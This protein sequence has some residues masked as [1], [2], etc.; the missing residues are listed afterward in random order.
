MNNLDSILKSRDITL[1]TKAHLV[2]AMVFPGVMNGCESQS[3]KKAECQRT[4]TFELW[5]GRRLLRVPQRAG[6]SNQSIL[7]ETSPK[8]SL[9]GLILKLKLQCFGH[10]MQRT[11]PLEKNLMLGT[12]EGKRRRGKQR[13]R[14]LDGISNSMDMIL[15]CMEKKRET[16]S[17]TLAWR[18]P[19]TEEP[20][21]LHSMGSQRVRHN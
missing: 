11:D 13:M 20:G 2:K 7:R 15:S 16:H 6:R 12:I 1:P 18:I 14:W 19:W 3:I 8:Y 17:S 10:L 21:G 5:C 4:D 9:E